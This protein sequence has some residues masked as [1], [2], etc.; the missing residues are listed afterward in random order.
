[1]NQLHIPPDEFRMLAAR[2]SSIAADYYA[3]L[4]DERSFPRVSGH[5]TRE[6]FDEPLTQEGLHGAAL[7]ALVKVMDMSR[8]PGARFFG[9]VLGSGEPVAALADLL[10]SV[11]N[12]NVTAWRSAPAAV[13]IERQVV[14][15]IADALG[16]GGM[17][18]N[19]CGGGSSANLMA[20][21]MAREARLPANECGASPGVV[22]VSSEAHMS[23]A[24]AVA[25]LGL[26]RRN[27]HLV[28]MDVSA[29][30]AAI[31]EDRAAGRAMIAVVA[32]AGTG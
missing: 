19:L 26:G 23:M 32:S 6:A 5:E 29:L 12:Q 28:R 21:A 11:L 3:R 13:M 15:W 7:D 25:L 24:K 30:E 1:M 27:L 14:R 22:Y 17:S 20:L 4:P 8:P 10:A 31:A 18:G 9:Y 2:V 16:C